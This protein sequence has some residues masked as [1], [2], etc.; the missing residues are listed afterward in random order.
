MMQ[1]ASME[2]IFLIYAVLVTEKYPSFKG[3][4]CV[5]ETTREDAG[6][7]QAVAADG[8]CYCGGRCA[9]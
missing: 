7:D 3:D 2:R 1:C 9:K 6:S 5:G 8:Q 4:D